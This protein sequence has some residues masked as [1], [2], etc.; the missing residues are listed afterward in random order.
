MLLQQTGGLRERPEVPD[1]GGG[2]RGVIRRMAL[3][4]RLVTTKAT[5]RRPSRVPLIRRRAGGI[6][7][8]QPP[9]NSF[10]QPRVG[11][12]LVVVAAASTS[13]DP[14]PGKATKGAPATISCRGLWASSL[15]LL[16]RV[17]RSLTAEA[18]GWV[19]APRR[20]MIEGK[21]IEAATDEI[22]GHRST[23]GAAPRWFYRLIHSVE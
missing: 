19:G 9:E 17:P 3:S 1:R 10:S 16:R 23:S 8:L 4:G 13:G 20:H 2:A 6:V 14:I 15:A 11:T 5:R 21:A 7:I 22:H 18:T 12:R